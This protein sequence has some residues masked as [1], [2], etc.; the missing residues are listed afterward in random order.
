MKCEFCGRELETRKVPYLRFEIPVPCDCD[1][2]K[3]QREEEDRNEREENWTKE[4]LMAIDRARIPR[5]YR[6][7][8]TFGDGR[9]LYLYGM[10][11]RGKT[12][13]ACGALRAYIRS[14]IVEEGHNRF[15]ATKSAK[16]VSVPEW[17]ME[18]RRTYDVRGQS[19]GDLM[20]SYAGVGTLCLDD[21][22]KGQMTPWAIERIYTLLDLRYREERT[23]II[24]S[25]YDGNGLIRVIAS[26]SDEE[27]A[28]AIWSR[29]QGMC[30]IRE[31]GGPDWR[32]A[33]Q[34][35]Q[36]EGRQDMI[37]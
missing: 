13:M 5:R 21:L 11:G 3:R 24:T 2:A 19:E 28:Y 16:F 15:F 30:Q 18:M 34:N 23:T 31:V 33:A 36:R 37:Y 25:Q 9:G 7:Y 17:L 29:I 14:G 6:L 22:G 27:S 4:Y 8:E 10:Q 1:A 32:R 35:S 20:E 12:E 26:R